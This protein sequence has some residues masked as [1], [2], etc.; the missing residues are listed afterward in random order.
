MRDYLVALVYQSGN[1]DWLVVRN[2]MEGIKPQLVKTWKVRT[3]QNGALLT[4]NGVE[5]ELGSSAASIAFDVERA[6]AGWNAPDDE[7]R[8]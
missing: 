3:T 5:F 4:L 2:K 1:L 6:A 8:T 7:R